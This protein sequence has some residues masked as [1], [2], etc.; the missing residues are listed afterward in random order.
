MKRLRK[1]C[2]FLTALGLLVLLAGCGGGQDGGASKAG[3]ASNAEEA[4]QSGETEPDAGTE[5]ELSL[6]ERAEQEQTAAE[7]DWAAAE[8]AE[9]L[10]WIR[11]AMIG[12]DYVCAVA[13][14]GYTD[15]ELL[16]PDNIG[17]FLD[18]TAYS[19]LMFLEQMPERAF[20]NYAGSE[21]YLI[22]PRDEDAFVLAAEWIL[23]E[24]NNYEGELGEPLYT[25][26]KGHPFVLVGNVSDMMP[27]IA[28]RIETPD[29][30]T[31]T[32]TPG[33]SLRDGTLLV[34]EEPPLV[35]DC[36]TYGD[37]EVMAGISPAD[38]ATDQWNNWS[39]Q[40]DTEDG[41]TLSGSL[42]FHPDGTMDYS[43]G[44]S[45]EVFF[46]TFYTGSWSMD[47]DTALFD[48]ALLSDTSGK[49]YPAE[50]HGRYLLYWNPTE[51]GAGL[52]VVHQ[53]GTPLTL[54]GMEY[55]WTLFTE[56]MG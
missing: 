49:E 23:N 45:G 41:G 44:P 19:D 17:A 14:L 27:N 39:A 2:A 3:N 55:A 47:G 37:G 22:I 51:E 30:E 11:Q 25:S 52:A 4:E 7:A 13:Y 24:E 10:L 40:Y 36:T 53:D 8:S 43:F 38:A 31:L 54:D 18:G 56:A 33:M 29:G 15:G 42:E 9:A 46:T 5:A 28:V 26:D 1:L 48:M 20:I 12:T 6:G 32:Y 34:P 50:F 35:M 16:G 21:A